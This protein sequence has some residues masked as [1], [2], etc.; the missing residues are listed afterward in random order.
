MGRGRAR[1]AASA[2]ALLVACAPG[3]E[4]GLTRLS[5]WESMEPA[6]QAMLADHLE[7]FEATH[8]GVEVEALHFPPEALRNQFQ[9]A[10][11]ARTGPDLVYGPSDNVG[12]FSIMGLIQPLEGLLPA[13]SLELYLEDAKPSLEGHLYALADQVGN[14]LTMVR[15]RALLPDAPRDTAEMME[16]ARRLTVDADGDGRPE[17][18]G[19]VFS[20]SEPFWLAPWLGGHGGWVLD[21]EGEPTLDGPAMEGALGFLRQLVEARVIPPGCDYP[22]ADTLFKQGKAAMLVNGPWS[23]ESYREAGIDVGLSLLP[24]VVETGLWP[25]PMTACRAYSLNMHS[26]PG[27]RELVLELLQYLTSAEVVGALSTGI[28][29]LPSRHDVARWPAVAQDP[30]V[31]ASWEQ[32]QKGRLM[33]VVPEMRVIWDVM[34]PGMQ[35]VISGSGTPDEAADRMQADAVRKI[36][37]MRL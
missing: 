35:R 4:E 20:L 17:Q 23:W 36:R 37:E 16:A 21:E 8:P 26:P 18:Y 19:I 5:I 25:S 11:L 31:R 15:N 27:H 33:P 10:A 28:G 9:T 2:V 32:L 1:L 34:R 6:E 12:P 7:A 3:D 29:S 22:L 13:D 30:T 14:H 24:R